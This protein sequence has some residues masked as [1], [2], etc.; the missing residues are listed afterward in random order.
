MGVTSIQSCPFDE[1]L[2]VVGSYDESVS[3]WDHRS[4]RRPLTDVKV[5]GGVWR[6][7]W[8]PEDER[9]IL[10]ACMYNEFQLLQYQDT[11]IKLLG[12]LFG[13]PQHEA[14]KLAYGADWFRHSSPSGP[15]YH[16]AVCSFYDNTYS[17]WDFEIN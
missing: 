5:G 8:H 4:T 12:G 10:A 16:A 15:L 13:S 7:K 17:C 6:V 14:G 3:I 2:I 9:V 1:N 11:E